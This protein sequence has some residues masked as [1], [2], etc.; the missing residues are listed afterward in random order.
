MLPKTLTLTKKY[1]LCPVKSVPVSAQTSDDFGAA[2]GSTNQENNDSS[3]VPSEPN[4]PQQEPVLLRSNLKSQPPRPFWGCSSHTASGMLGYIVENKF[5]EIKLVDL[6]YEV[7]SQLSL[8]HSSYSGLA[9][10]HCQLSG[11]ALTA[12]TAQRQLA[13]AL[14]LT[15]R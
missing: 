4:E 13:A 11:T 1:K 14:L 12:L 2:D 6:F 5:G 10:Q 9:C 8:T 7:G 15:S 3:V